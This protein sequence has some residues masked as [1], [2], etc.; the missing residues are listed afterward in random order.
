MVCP[1]GPNPL[2]SSL[3][4]PYTQDQSCDSH[5]VSPG[6][7]SHC[8]PR[9]PFHLLLCHRLQGIILSPTLSLF[10]AP[11]SSCFLPARHYYLSH[12]P[13]IFPQG[14]VSCANL[15]MQILKHSTEHKVSSQG[16]WVGWHNWGKCKSK[17]CLPGAYPPALEM[18]AT[19]MA[20]Q[21]CA[22]ARGVKCGRDAAQA[23]GNECGCKSRKNRVDPWIVHELECQHPVQL[24]ICV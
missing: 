7:Y 22:E 3:T 19:S 23:I 14:L 13:T 21:G 16:C 20:K 2:S 5:W 18:V 12:L 6:L 8:S 1:N 17:T 24:K 10:Q 4:V 15:L 9:V 11:Q